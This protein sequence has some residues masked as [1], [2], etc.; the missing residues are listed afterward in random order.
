MNLG[1]F[2]AAVG[3]DIAHKTPEER[4]KLVEGLD[5]I[6]TMIASRLAW[7]STMLGGP[8]EFASYAS[9]SASN[10]ELFPQH[11]AGGAIAGQI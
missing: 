5:A 1:I 10:I 6:R 8:P 3:R 11:R 2:I 9:F 7:L 4:Q